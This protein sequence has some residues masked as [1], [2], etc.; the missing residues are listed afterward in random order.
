[1]TSRA[2]AKAL[3]NGAGFGLAHPEVAGEQRDR[4]GDHPESHRDH[5]RDGS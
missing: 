3:D 2:A 1:V 4:R 5:E